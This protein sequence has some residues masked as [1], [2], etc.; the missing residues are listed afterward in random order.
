MIRREHLRMARAGLDW[1]LNDLAK[2]AK[3]NPNTISRYETGR[4]IM[5]ETLRKIEET[6]IAAGVRFIDDG[7]IVGVQVKK[8]SAT[9]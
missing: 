6:L 1:T 5:S 3:V 4:D 8:P 7:D 2:V 9:R